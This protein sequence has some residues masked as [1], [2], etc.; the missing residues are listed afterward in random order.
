MLCKRNDY[1][2]LTVARQRLCA[3]EYYFARTACIGEDFVARDY[4]I[5]YRMTGIIQCFSIQYIMIVM[6]QR[7]SNFLWYT[8]IKTK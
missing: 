5:L 1:R 8:R 4:I 3:R 6:D 7:F 2:K